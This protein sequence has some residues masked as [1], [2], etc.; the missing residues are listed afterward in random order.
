M[1]K[2]KA[3]AATAQKKPARKMPRKTAQASTKGRKAAAAKAP[4]KK[5]GMKKKAAAKK[6]LVKKPAVKKAVAKKPA[7]KKT[8]PKK[9][10]PKKAAIKKTALKKSLLKKSPVKAVA[11]K[12]GKVKAAVKKAAAKVAAKAAPGKASMKASS[13]KPVKSPARKGANNNSAGKGKKQ[14]IK[15]ARVIGADEPAAFVLENPEGTSAVLVVCDHANNRVPASLDNLGMSDEERDMH[16]AWD[17]GTQD[18]GRY[19]G[20]KLQAQ[21]LLAQYS[22]LVVDLNR[23]HNHK[24]CM[25]D[26]SDHVAVPGNRNLSPAARKQRLEE[27]YWPYHNE[28]D[29]LIDDRLSEGV[30]P[31]LM[32]IHSFTPR[33]D[34]FDRPWHIGVLWNREAGLARQL[35]ENLRAQNPDIVVGENEPYS[36]IG[37]VGG[38]DTVQRHAEDRDL[39]YIIV[40]FRQDLVR[41]REGAE[42]WAEIFLKAVRPIIEDAATYSDQRLK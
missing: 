4:L 18:I 34:G 30:I 35:V 15:A 36:L 42:E 6:T 7:T 33:M 14:A 23:G 25:R 37:H 10:A 3:K 24:E 40:E 16:I 21:V 19:L 17:P 1:K 8:T 11:K 22:R 5:A 41:T 31:L 32:S 2:K 13:G 26:V 12:A 38:K 28:I 39:P 20:R 27:I 29:R 9:A